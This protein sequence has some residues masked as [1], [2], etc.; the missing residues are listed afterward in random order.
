ME[1]LEC[2]IE[3]IASMLSQGRWVGI[4]LT[5]R[6]TSKHGHFKEHIHRYVSNSYCSSVLAVF[7]P[8][9]QIGVSS[10]Q[11][12]KRFN[13]AKAI[14]LTSSHWAVYRPYLSVRTATYVARTWPERTLWEQ[15][16]GGGGDS[17]Q[18]FFPQRCLLVM[19]NFFFLS[20]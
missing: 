18:V 16:G 1:F 19:I 15:Q 6:V 8:W 4:D 13:A 20:F 5:L 10:L 12:E 9:S 3:E 14:V 2:S 11:W 7:G 17:D